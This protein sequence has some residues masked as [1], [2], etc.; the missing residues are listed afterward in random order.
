MR[1]PKNAIRAVLALGVVLLA[2]SSPGLTVPGREYSRC[3]HACNFIARA[4][5][6]RCH[7]D[8]AAL[9]HGDQA[10]ISVCRAECLASVEEQFMDCRFLCR[11]VIVE[12]PI[13][14]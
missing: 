9:F 12:D 6:E 10:L 7:T 13:E 4:A 11:D 2:F 5:A 14:P 3:I 8:C 1:R